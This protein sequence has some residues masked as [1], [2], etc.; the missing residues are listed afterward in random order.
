M[1]YSDCHNAPV[2]D[3]YTGHC[4]PRCLNICEIWSD[5]PDDPDFDS[6]RTLSMENIKEDVRAARMNNAEYERYG[7]DD[8]RDDPEDER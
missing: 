3:Y 1:R 2:P 7:S 6:G 4:C 5:N 8:D